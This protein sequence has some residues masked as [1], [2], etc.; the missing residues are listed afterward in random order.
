MFVERRDASQRAWVPCVSKTLVTDGNLRKLM[1]SMARFTTSFALMLN[2]R[3]TVRSQRR[4]RRFCS[5]SPKVSTSFTFNLAHC[6]FYVGYYSWFH[7]LADD[8]RQFVNGRQNIMLYSVKNYGPC[9]HPP[10]LTSWWPPM[11][12]DGWPNVSYDVH[13]LNLAYP[14]ELFG[15]K[16]FIHT[17]TGSCEV[18]VCQANQV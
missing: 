3:K 2:D 10:L 17:T 16:P 5:C 11:L 1:Q 8:T 4:R 6:V 7:C 9:N 12:M 18:Y 14:S 15:T 13:V